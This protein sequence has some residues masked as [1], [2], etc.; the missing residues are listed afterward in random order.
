MYQ[1]FFQCEEK[2]KKTN[3]LNHS[4]KCILLKY[5][6]ILFLKWK[7]NGIKSIISDLHKI[8]KINKLYI[9]YNMIRIFMIYLKKASCFSWMW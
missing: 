8:I 3:F 7:I 2:K 9:N 4:V 6:P 1:V 5:I